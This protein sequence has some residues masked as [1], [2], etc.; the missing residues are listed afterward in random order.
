MKLGSPAGLQGPGH[1]H[2]LCL[3]LYPPPTPPPE[4]L[5]QFLGEGQWP[6]CVTVVG[7]VLSEEQFFPSLS[8]LSF[9]DFLAQGPSWIKA[10]LGEGQ[11]SSVFVVRKSWN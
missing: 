10:S 11:Q 9:N 8:V 4:A 3:T 5:P 6:Q 1:K 7:F 2:P